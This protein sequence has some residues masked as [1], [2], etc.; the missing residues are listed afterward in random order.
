MAIIYF[1]VNIILDFPIT[2]NIALV[3]CKS[4]CACLNQTANMVVFFTTKY[5]NTYSKGRALVQL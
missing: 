3:V 2:Q 5:E 4:E 1:H